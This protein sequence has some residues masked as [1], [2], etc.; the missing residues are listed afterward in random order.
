[1]V[2]TLAVGPAH[3]QS[4]GSAIIEGLASVTD[5]DTIEIAGQ[6]IRLYG[7]DA[8]ESEQR[9]RTAEGRVWHCGQEATAALAAKIGNA[10]VACEVRDH[11]GRAIAVCRQGGADLNAWM[12]E[13]GLALAYRYFSTDY[14]PEEESAR[15]AR[16]GLWQGDFVP[17]WKWRRG[18][19]L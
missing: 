12:V 3:A 9:C 1:M 11:D 8:P 7:I 6:W 13:Q 18:K 17:P 14:V 19:R 4:G 5:G 2:A 10:P 16:R 15:R